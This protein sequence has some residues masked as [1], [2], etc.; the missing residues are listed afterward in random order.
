MEAGGRALF[1]IFLLHCSPAAL[2]ARGTAFVTVPIA[3]FYLFAFI[4]ISLFLLSVAL[5][6]ALSFSPTVRATSQ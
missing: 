4:S 6:A 1:R 2:I 5:P 3:C